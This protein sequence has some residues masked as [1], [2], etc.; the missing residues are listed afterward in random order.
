M[1]YTLRDF[2]YLL[3]KFSVIRSQTWIDYFEFIFHVMIAMKI[4]FYIVDI[5]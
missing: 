3:N 5:F 1:H 4:L 2:E